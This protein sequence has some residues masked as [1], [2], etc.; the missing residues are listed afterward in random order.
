MPLRRK[1]GDVAVPVQQVES[2]II[3]AKK[4]IVDDIVPDEVLAAQRIE[5]RCQIAPVEK[6]VVRQALDHLELPSIDE[7][8]E[9]AASLEI[10][11]RSE[12]SRDLHL[13]RFA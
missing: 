11:L 7:V 1:V 8:F 4:V 9:L 2:R 6:A 10:D 5:G 3:F 12:E 13:F